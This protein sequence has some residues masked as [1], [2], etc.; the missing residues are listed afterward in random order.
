MSV[1][2]TLSLAVVEILARSRRR[3]CVRVSHLRWHQCGLSDTTETH[4]HTILSPVWVT[5]NPEDHS[6][7]NAY[8]C[9]SNL[10]LIEAVVIFESDIE[11]QCVRRVYVGGSQSRTPRRM[12]VEKF[13][14]LIS[15]IQICII[16]TPKNRYRTPRRMA[17]NKHC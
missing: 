11:C 10:P 17:D 1:T 6:H 13:S 9:E 14:T 2:L 4:R 3:S 15:L 12:P 8:E 16:L 7:H 5:D